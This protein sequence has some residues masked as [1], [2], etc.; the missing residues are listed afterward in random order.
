ML[1]LNKN[2]KTYIY[3]PMNVLSLPLYAAA[4]KKPP[5]KTQTNNWFQ[6]TICDEHTSGFLHYVDK[7]CSYI[8]FI[9]LF[10]ASGISWLCQNS[11]NN[12]SCASFTV[13]IVHISLILP[14]I[15]L[16]YSYVLF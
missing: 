16:D 14:F 4:D 5:K 2:D 10:S 9:M 11:K 7:N 8:W 12:I 15:Y 6:T 13:F 1:C 3:I